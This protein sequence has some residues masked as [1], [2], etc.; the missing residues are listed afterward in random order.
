MDYSREKDIFEDIDMESEEEAEFQYLIEAAEEARRNV[1]CPY[2]GFSVGAAVLTEDGFVYLGSNIENA[3]YPLGNCAERTAIFK[4]V[5]EGN[6]KFRAIAISGGPDEQ[7]GHAECP[8]CGACRQV[9]REFFGGDAK[10]IF[11][12]KGK[13]YH[14]MTLD[15]LLPKSFGPENL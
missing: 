14:T 15:E 12:G 2:S 13:S 7:P 3:S 9:M 5:S 4:A 6:R 8:P 10:V 1:Y 11:S